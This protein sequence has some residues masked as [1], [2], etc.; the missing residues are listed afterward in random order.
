M[1]LT[2][3]LN[4]LH[5]GNTFKKTW[6]VQRKRKVV[7]YGVKQYLESKKPGVQVVDA[8]DL[9]GLKPVPPPEPLAYNNSLELKLRR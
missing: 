4:T 3:V 8:C 5:I 2:N 1:R 9:L 7:D 6:E